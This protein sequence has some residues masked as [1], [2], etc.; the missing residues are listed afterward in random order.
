VKKDLRKIAAGVHVPLWRC[1]VVDD[2]PS[3]SQATQRTPC[4][5]PPGMD[6]DGTL[7]A[8]ASFLLAAAGI[9][10]GS[11]W[12]AGH[13]RLAARVISRWGPERRE[14]TRGTCWATRR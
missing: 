9:S 11:G 13:V 5:S 3:T 8:L 12:A 10:R 1:L 14:S 7:P 4:P 2:T 6:A